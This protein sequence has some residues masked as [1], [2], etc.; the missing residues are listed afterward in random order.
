M[1]FPLWY[2]SKNNSHV[3]DYLCVS[4]VMFN[5]FALDI[6]K[7]TVFHIKNYA[8]PRVNVCWLFLKLNRKGE[9]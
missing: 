7:C 2:V 9:P 6:S 4:Y 5:F 8:S 3:N 1:Q